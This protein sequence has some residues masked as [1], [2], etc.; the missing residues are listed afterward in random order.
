V[1]FEKALAVARKQQAKSWELRAGD[2][3]E[4]GLATT[5]QEGRSPASCWRRY[6]TGSRR[7]LTPK[8]LQREG[9]GPPPPK[10]GPFLLGERN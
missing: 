3:L 9:G 5:E 10:G 8:D 7:A 6:T 2:E 1:F 4:A